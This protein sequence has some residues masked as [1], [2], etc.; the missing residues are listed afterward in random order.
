MFRIILLAVIS[1]FLYFTTSAQ[2]VL[3]W[4]QQTADLGMILEENGLVAVDFTFTNKGT[5]K[6]KITEIIADCGCT[7]GE[8]TQDSVSIDA[9]GKVQV[10]FDPHNRPGAFSKMILVKNSTS[11]QADTLFITGQ[12]LAMPVNVERYYPL[13]IG[14]LRV[15]QKTIELG[16]VINN[17][18]T[19]KNIEVYNASEDSLAID[20]TSV[21]FPSHVAVSFI[22]NK[23]APKSRGFMTVA[24]D[25]AKK[26]ELGFQQDLISFKTSP[27]AGEYYQWPLVAYIN[28]YFSPLSKEELAIAPKLKVS[29]L[30]IELGNIS[31]D[32]VVTKSLTLKNDGKQN[33]LFRKVETNCVCVTVS[34]TLD[35]LQPGEEIVISISFDPKDRFGIDHK[36]ITFFTNDP[37]MPTLT[38]TL[39]STIQ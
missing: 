35:V 22:P 20:Y 23:L 31:A 7:T 29:A 11:A 9:Q 6:L 30:E 34:P 14:F 3:Q 10:T 28:E 12:V 32:Q 25:G 27:D 1:S 39:K 33:L 17:S 21:N 2:S 15:R 24:Y 18:R 37:Q 36:F 8:F 4:D 5:E 13:Q 19:T 38:V 26:G 16:Q